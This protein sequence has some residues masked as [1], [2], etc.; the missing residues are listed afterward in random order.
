MPL[1]DPK[2]D[3]PYSYVRTEIRVLKSIRSGLADASKVDSLVVIP[4]SDPQRLHKLVER[5]EIMNAVADDYN[6]AIELLKP[7]QNSTNDNVRTSVT[8]FNEGIGATKQ[9]DARLLEM[10]E[11]FDK[12]TTADDFDQPAIAKQLADLNGIKADARK[13]IIMA[14]KA[15]SFGILKGVGGDD[16]WK[17][18][19]F[20][21]TEQQRAKLLAEAKELAKRQAGTETYVD[22]CADFLV[23]TLTKNLPT[24]PE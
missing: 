24:I 13:L 6:C 21:I 23:D 5:N 11:S 20:T 7:Y 16:E 2:P 19:A 9:V 3:S 8:G 17:P 22:V 4:A 15:S 14:V 12:A 10:M 18:V 1:G